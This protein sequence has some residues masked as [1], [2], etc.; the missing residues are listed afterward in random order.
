MLGSVFQFIWVCDCG[1]CAATGDSFAIWTSTVIRRGYTYY[2]GM[3][4]RLKDYVNAES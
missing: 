1:R 3:G 4:L 2:I